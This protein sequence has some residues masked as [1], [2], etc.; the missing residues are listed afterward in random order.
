MKGS[1]L[2]LEDEL[3][4]D[5]DELEEDELDVG[6]VLVVERVDREDGGKVAETRE[7]MEELSEDVLVSVHVL[8]SLVLDVLVEVDVEV[9][10]DVLDVLVEVEELDVFLDDRLIIEGGLHPVEEVCL[11]VLHVRLS[12]SL[13]VQDMLEYKGVVVTGLALLSALIELY[14]CEDFSALSRSSQSE[15]EQE[16]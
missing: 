15:S 9:G 16:Q 6:L 13:L 7:V 8:E 4:L 5:E 1:R 11:F 3:E 10:R 2:E 14:L 12:S